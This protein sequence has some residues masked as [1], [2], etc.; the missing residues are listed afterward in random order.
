V[1]AYFSISLGLLCSAM[2][3]F[4]ASAEPSVPHLR[5][6]Q[7]I[8]D[9][10]PFFVR[11]G[12][13]SNSHGEPDYL[14]PS[15]AKLRALNLNTVLAPV[16]WNLIEAEE[17][18]FDFATVEGLL[19]DARANDMRLVLLWF[20]SWKNS[21]SAYVPAWVK[22]DTMRFPRVLDSAGRAHEILSPF[23]AAN[24]EADSRAFA[25]L[26]RYLRENDGEH[27]VILVQVENEIG[28]IPEPRDHRPEADQAFSG[29][30]PA[31][32]LKSLRER[33]AS[34]S[35]ATN[36]LLR[37]RARVGAHIEEGTWAEVF[38][39]GVEAEEIFMAW[40]F[41]CYTEQVASAGL[42]ELALPL[43]TNAALIRPGYQPGQYPSG[44]PLPH[45]FDV[46]RAGA[47]SLSFLAPDIYF[48]NFTYWARH[49]AR[50]ANP[51]FIPEALRSNEAAIHALYVLGE[52]RAI[53]FSPFAIESTPEPTA[54]YLAASYDLIRQLTP[55]FR[56]SHEKSGARQSAG[57]L[58]ESAETKQ[59]QQVRLGN[60]TIYAHFEHTAPYSLGEGGAVIVGQDNSVFDGVGV[61]G[62]MPGQLSP[63]GG[64]VLMLGE[65]EFLFAGMGL[66]LTF[67]SAET[68]AWQAGLLN[69]EEGRFDEHGDWQHVRWLNGDQTHQGRH[70]RLEPGRFC[71]QRVRLYRYR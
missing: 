28:M 34:D 46:W 37:G 59:P 27:T 71:I 64:L 38:G 40:Q 6:G 11:G 57:L 5:E 43:Y 44:G 3:V 69:V 68:G 7:L 20:G 8:V 31:A 26:M 15:W 16:Y 47:P 19:A 45:L 21:M 30:V 32:L 18:Q 53:G 58:K 62:A 63:A 48:Q 29:P 9:G 24:A 56:P 49:Y 60:W 41:A 51:L 13:L 54:S 42:A 66:T 50:D 52:H 65:D 67:A 25:A 4:A 12:E 2:T 70:V 55:L 39:E 17:G 22:R 35:L 61:A 14:R 10:R 23:V 36:Q 1:S 33:A